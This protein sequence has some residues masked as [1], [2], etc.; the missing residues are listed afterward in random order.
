M[1]SVQTAKTEINKVSNKNSVENAKKNILHLI[2]SKGISGIGGG[3]QSL[4]K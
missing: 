3:G 1:I 4:V 2:N